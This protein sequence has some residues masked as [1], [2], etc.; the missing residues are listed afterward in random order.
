[1]RIRAARIFVAIAFSACAA[2]TGVA[3]GH[4]GLQAAVHRVSH[5]HAVHPHVAT[6]ALSR[7]LGSVKVP[8]TGPIATD[9]L[10]VLVAAASVGMCMRLRRSRLV[11]QRLTAIRSGRGCRAPPSR[12]L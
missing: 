7:A 12:R 9:A 11:S 2:V 1:M 10:V 6:P 4:W 3:V 5:A 8:G